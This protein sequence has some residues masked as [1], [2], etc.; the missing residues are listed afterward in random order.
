MEA[1]KKK[2]V[3][4][5]WFL[6]VFED[7]DNAKIMA[8]HGKLLMSAFFL[9]QTVEKLLKVYYIFLKNEEP[10]YVHNLF[11][12]KQKTDV[13]NLVS[14]DLVELIDQ[15]NPYYIQSRYPSYKEKISLNL[16]KKVIAEFIKRTEELIKCLQLEMKLKK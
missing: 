15:L 9:Q 5:K 16:D 13:Q 8:K 4:K 10:P 6:L 11:L 2:R 7:F 1:Q 14:S 3:L 12:L